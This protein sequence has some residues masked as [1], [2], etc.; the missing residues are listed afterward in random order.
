M[1]RDP[2]GI[3]G[4]RCESCLRTVAVSRCSATWMRE[5]LLCAPCADRW[6]LA[7]DAKLAERGVRPV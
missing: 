4:R 6:W 7:V 3:A 2:Y 1:N 5:R